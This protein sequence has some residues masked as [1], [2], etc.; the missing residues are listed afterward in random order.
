MIEFNKTMLGHFTDEQAVFASFDAD[1][2]APFETN[3]Q[4]TIND[5]EMMPTDETIKDQLQQLTAKVEDAMEKCRIK[6]QNSKY[7][8]EKAF[9]ESPA[10]RNEFG[11]DDYDQARK[12]QVGMLQFMRTFFTT[13]NKYAAELDAVGYNAASISEIETLGIDLDKDNNEQEKFKGTRSVTA[14]ERVKALNKTWDIMVPVSKAGKV[15]FMNDPAKYQLFLL[16]ASSETGE[17]ISISGTVTET[18][19]TPLQDVTVKVDGL[20]VET[21]TDSNGNYVIGN[22]PAGTYSLTYTKDGYQPQTVAG[23]SVTTSK[24][25]DVDVQMVPT[26]P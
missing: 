2:T 14:E 15:I 3:W 9:P 4:T 1:F 16:P 21:T 22:L 23:V 17:N 10:I 18:A 6:F 11:F 26:A 12:S 5:A 13:A 20:E 24:I 7:F 19:D 8:I 25:T